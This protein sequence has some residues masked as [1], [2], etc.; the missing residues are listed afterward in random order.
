MGK[1]KVKFILIACLGILCIAI[2]IIFA[3]F[4]QNT[5]HLDDVKIA[6]ILPGEIN[7]QSWNAGN[8]KGIIECREEM[9]IDLKCEQ[10]V[11]EADFEAVLRRYAQEGYQFIIAAGTQF[12]ET[13]SVV[14]NDYPNADF[15]IING[16]NSTQSNVFAVYPKEN[17]ASH[18]AAVMAGN[19]TEKGMFG[20]IA[21]YPSEPM[22]EL[23]DQYDKDVREIAENR[24]IGNPQVFRAYANSWDDEQLGKEIAEQMIG[25]G[26]DVLFIYAN[27]VGLGCIEAAKEHHIKVIGFSENQN[28]IDSDTVVASVEFDF[29]AI[30]KWTISHYLNGKL[31]GNKAYGIGI[32]E[33]IFKPVYSEG[34]PL[35]VREEIDAAISGS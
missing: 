7:D 35:D 16:R 9:Q 3:F 30:Y 23:L 15:C 28:Q 4:N 34:F 6:V 24:E 13:V 31:K 22:E 14:A 32:Q 17:E 11:A 27:K 18:L 33:N 10:G 25:K 5:E 1:N 2:C 26:A 19:V 12:E 20:I 21:G 29:G 8:Y